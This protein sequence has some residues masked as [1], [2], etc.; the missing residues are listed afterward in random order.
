VRERFQLGGRFVS[1]GDTLPP[2]GRAGIAL[3]GAV[4]LTAAAGGAAP[5][6]IAAT[7]GVLP[8]VLL[9]TA[10]YWGATRPQL[11]RSL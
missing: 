6:V 2:L 5:A 7:G 9:L 1:G 11:P 3:C 8:G 10:S 4:G